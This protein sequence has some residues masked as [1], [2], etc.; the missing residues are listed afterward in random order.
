MARE[1]A[2]TTVTWLVAMFKRQH[3]NHDSPPHMNRTGFSRREWLKCSS[4]LGLSL[5]AP[6]TGTAQPARRIDGNSQVVD[7]SDLDGKLP[8]DVVSTIQVLKQTENWEHSTWKNPRWPAGGGDTV[9]YPSVVHNVEGSKPDGKYYL[10]YAHHDPRSGIGVAVAD[11]ITGPYS[12]KVRVPG[13]ADN[14]VVP[15]FHASS[16]NPD[17]PSHN[18]SPWVVW[19]DREN[20]W[21]MYF[22]F[23]NHAHGAKTNFQPTALAT[24]PDL[25]SHRW[26]IWADKA[27]RT[28]PNWVAVLPTTNKLWANEASSYNTV[29]RLPDGRWLGFVRG[30]S[31]DGKPTRLGFALS[32]DGRHFKYLDQNPIIHAGDGGGGRQGVY[33]PGFIG[34]LGKNKTGRDSYLVAWQESHPFD[35]DP[36]LIYGYTTD[37]KRVKRDSRGHVR[38]KG[39]DG[40][41]SAWRI[42]SRLYLFSGKFLHEMKLPV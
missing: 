6:T 16:R 11:A 35:G 34:Y 20:L 40:S 10:Y 21:F 42:G 39:S 4:A 13:R 38:W 8:L 32:R 7:L 30:T 24:T 5:A 41:L 3:E 14:Q 15:S 19:N 26:T 33:R 22:P 23:F 27:V 29:H 28:I 1:P 12:K 31:N 36:R 17:D 37:F 9:G 18:S 2:S 25:A